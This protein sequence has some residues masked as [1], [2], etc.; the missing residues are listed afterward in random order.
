MKK[1]II[2]TFLLCVAV[3]ACYSQPYTLEVIISGTIMGSTVTI[4]PPGPEYTEPTTVTLTANNRGSEFFD[5][6]GGDLSGNDNPATIYVDGEKTVYVQFVLGDAPPKNS[7][8]FEP[9]PLQLKAGMTKDTSVLCNSRDQNLAAYGFI[10]T[11]DPA[12]VRINTAQYSDG[13]SAGA[14]GFIAALNAVIPGKLT[15]AGFDVTGKGPGSRL[16]VLDIAWEGVADGTTTLDLYVDSIIDSNQNSLGIRQGIDGTIIVTSCLL[17]GDVNG[18]GQVNIVDAL[19]IAQD[20]VG[21]NP[22]NFDRDC[23]DVD[24]NGIITI[25]DALLIA[26]YYVNIIPGFCL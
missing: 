13:V 1:S 22:P 7:I 20:Y 8:W 18:D 21:L 19:L 10:I 15:V 16:H 11:F 5:G 25:L 12:I 17:P 23:A 2:M 14:D 6:W 24:C 26:Q 3:I 9:N 4:D